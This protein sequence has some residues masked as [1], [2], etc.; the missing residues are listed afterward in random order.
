VSSDNA[1][2]TAENVSATT[3]REMRIDLTRRS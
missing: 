3:S 2:K 1:R